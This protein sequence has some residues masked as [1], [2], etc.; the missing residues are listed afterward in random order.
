[1]A[2]GLEGKKAIVAEVNE[3]AS[4]ALS[5]VT[6]EYHGLTVEQMTELRVKAREA[7]VY[8]KVVR[9]T[10]AKRAVEDTEFACMADALVG[11]VICAFSIDAPGAAAR[12]VKDFAKEN[13]KLVATSV[14]I[15]GKLHGA[16]QLEAVAS[17][18][19]K[20]EAIASLMSVMNGP[21][22]KL[23]RTLN[24]FPS[25]ITRAVA[26]VRDQKKEAA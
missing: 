18:P 4:R 16:E 6:A 10:L 21:I 12:L 17:L 8:L 3:V 15:G 7:N 25:K 19:T 13:E 14:A 20:D 11:P 9:N 1:M 23:A 22:T 26:A 2:L 5:A 24:E